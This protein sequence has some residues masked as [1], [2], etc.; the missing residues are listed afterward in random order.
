MG[1][2]LRSLTTP[3]LI[4]VLMAVFA[5]IE[6]VFLSVG[7]IFSMLRQVSILGIVAAGMTSIVLTGEIDIS[8]GSV[9]SFI[10]CCV[11]LLMVRRGVDPVLACLLVIAFST[12]LIMINCLIIQFT[13]MPSMLAT[14]A[15]MSVYSGLA[16]LV[17]H[18]TPV[19][20]LPDSFRMLGQGYL[21][22]VPIPIIIVAIV[23]VTMGFIL[24]KTKIGREIYA[25]GSNREAARL[26]GIPVGKVLLVTAAM[27]G[28]LVGLAACAQTSRLFAGSPTGGLGLEMEA[29][30]AVVVGGVSFAGGKGKIGGVFL[31]VVLMGVLKNGLSIMGMSSYVQDIVKGLVLLIVVGLDCWQSRHAVE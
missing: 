11:G 5:F 30:T 17:T 13:G 31:G 3:I 24:E 26:S 7:N 27:C 4:V 29:L 9:V 8:V 6:P 2:T 14:L 21:G 10:S 28:A 20:G 23:Y 18:A 19:S 12:V 25:V 1:K 22:P 16:H 15:A